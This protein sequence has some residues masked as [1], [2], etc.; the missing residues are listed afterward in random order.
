MSGP[1]IWSICITVMTRPTI[2][3]PFGY[4]SPSRST[5]WK[6]GLK[7]AG[8]PLRDGKYALKESDPRKWRH[9]LLDVW[10][11]HQHEPAVQ[12]L[13]QSKLLFAQQLLTQVCRCIILTAICRSPS[14]TGIPNRPFAG[15]WTRHYKL[16]YVGTLADDDQ[17]LLASGAQ[18]LRC[19]CAAPASRAPCKPSHTANHPSFTK[20]RFAYKGATGDLLQ[21]LPHPSHP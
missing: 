2:P 21:L 4:G 15:F 11:R 17:V 14:T 7:A 6:P 10:R 16:A 5:R 13:Y 18:P 8:V 12:Q 20:S 19:I 1:I 3:S 9:Y